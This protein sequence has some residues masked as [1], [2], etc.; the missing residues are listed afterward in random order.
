MTYATWFKALADPMRVRLLN[1]LPVGEIAEH[2]SIGQSTASYSLTE[3]RFVLAEAR[4][5]STRYAVNDG[6]PECFP[7]A[8]RAITGLESE[9]AC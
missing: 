4:G 6:C 5:T 3:V 9:R 2:P 8:V 1:L 7:A